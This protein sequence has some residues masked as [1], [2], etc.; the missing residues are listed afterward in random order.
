M[1]EKLINQIHWANT[2]IIDWLKTEHK[3]SDEHLKLISHILNAEKVWVSRANLMEGDR[4]TFKVHPIEELSLLNDSC[5]LAWKELLQKDMQH[6]ISYKLFD[7]TP[8]ESTIETMIL[9][10]FSH[11]FHH[12]GQMAAIASSS[13]EKFP[14]VSYIAFA[15]K[16]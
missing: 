10:V 16:K 4:D 8:Y 15:R 2:I 7:G 14:N 13:G 6:E 5:H 1:I 3:R 11:G 12:I 9:H